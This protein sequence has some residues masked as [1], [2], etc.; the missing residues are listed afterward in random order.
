MKK[1]EGYNAPGRFTAMTGF[2]WTSSPGGNNLHRVVVLGDGADKT[3]QI[4]PY[5][6]FR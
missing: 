5:S 2:E 3:S 1:A 6:L 4:V